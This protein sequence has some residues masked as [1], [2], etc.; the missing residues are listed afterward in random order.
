MSLR[1]SLQSGSDTMAKV[2]SL[3]AGFTTLART[4]VGSLQSIRKP[5]EEAT[6]QEDDDA[7]LVQVSPSR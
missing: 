3:K 1:S 6:L 2:A 4:L 5:K 7:V